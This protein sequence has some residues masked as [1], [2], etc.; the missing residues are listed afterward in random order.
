M[1]F[2]IKQGLMTGD[3]LT[4]TG[5]TLGENVDKWM[6]ERG[7]SWEGQEIIRPLNNPIKETG[8]IRYVHR[9]LSHNLA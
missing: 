4:V 7:H 8:H 6:V 3:E 1:A 5:K 2:L 9:N